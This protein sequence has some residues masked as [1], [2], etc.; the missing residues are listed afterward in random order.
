MAKITQGI[1]KKLSPSEARASISL[2]KIAQKKAWSSQTC[3]LQRLPQSGPAVVTTATWLS[4]SQK[5]VGVISA[6]SCVRTWRPWENTWRLSTSHPDTP[7]VGTA[8]TSSTYAQSRGIGLSAGKLTSQRK[9]KNQWGISQN[10][11][12]KCHIQYKVWRKNPWEGSK[13]SEK[14]E[15]IKNKPKH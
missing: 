4:C 11:T 5:R 7:S 12:K 6:G 3:V 8:K 14:M 1:G 10:W 15:S 2:H 9:N 13:I